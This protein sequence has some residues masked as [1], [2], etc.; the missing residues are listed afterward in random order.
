MAVAT[1]VEIV[2]TTND[3]DKNTAANNGQNNSGSDSDGNNRIDTE[4]N[5]N[6]L[7]QKAQ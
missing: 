3:S 4:N 7:Q 1:T 5:S 6:Y 2:A